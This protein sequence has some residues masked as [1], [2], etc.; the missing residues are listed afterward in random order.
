MS[1][2]RAGALRPPDAAGT[3]SSSDCTEDGRLS[4]TTL[5]QITLVC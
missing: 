2:L 1:Y 5:G 4:F 3:S